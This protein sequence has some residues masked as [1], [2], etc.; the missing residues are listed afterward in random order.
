[1]HKH[2]FTAPFTLV[3]GRWPRVARGRKIAKAFFYELIKII[4]GLFLAETF[5]HAALRRR[6]EENRLR[7]RIECFNPNELFF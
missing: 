1:M 5:F 7:W 6:K 3:A 2:Y 4:C